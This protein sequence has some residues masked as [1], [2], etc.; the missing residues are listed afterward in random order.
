MAN[1]QKVFKQLTEIAKEEELRNP[2][3]QIEE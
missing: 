2:P 3:V 1:K